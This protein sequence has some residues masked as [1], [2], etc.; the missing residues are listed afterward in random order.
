MKIAI[1]TGS[2]GLIG[3][4]SVEFFSKKFDKVIGIDNNMREWFFG[5][6]ASTLWNKKRLI[7]LLS[8]YTHYDVDIREKDD[9]E[10][11]VRG[12]KTVL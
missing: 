8:N 10:K 2:T 11:I 3:S 5:N 7:H 9:I 6:D 4:E 12:I 1:V